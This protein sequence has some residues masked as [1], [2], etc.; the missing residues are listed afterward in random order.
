MRVEYALGRLGG[1]GVSVESLNET[2]KGLQ[3]DPFEIVVK[4]VVVQGMSGVQARV[5]LGEKSADHPSWS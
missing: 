5:M 1:L 3:V 4:D 2:L